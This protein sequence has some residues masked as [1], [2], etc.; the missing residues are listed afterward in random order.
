MNTGEALWLHVPTGEIVDVREHESTVRSSPQTF[1]LTPEKAQ[2]IRTREDLLK[3]VMK[4][5]WVRMRRH[6]EYIAFEHMYPNRV[7]LNLALMRLMKERRGIIHSNDTI[8]VSHVTQGVDFEGKASEFIDR[9]AASRGREPANIPQDRDDWGRETEITDILRKRLL[10]RAGVWESAR[11]GKRLEMVLEETQKIQNELS[12]ATERG[13][14]GT[15]SE[16]GLARLWAKTK[17]PFAMLTGFRHENPLPVNIQFN[18]DILQFL[19]ARRMGAYKTIGYWREAPEGMAYL[20]AEKAGL[21]KDISEDSFFVP[22]PATMPL[23]DFREIVIQILRKYRQDA[24]IYGDGEKIVLLFRDGTEQQIGTKPTFNKIAQ[25]YSRMRNKPEV[26]F[27]FEG[28][29]VPINVISRMAF[30]ARG[31]LYPIED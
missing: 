14:I 25:A 9:Y 8:W 6:R 21:L 24:A 29:A 11:W 13:G 2:Q 1:G 10:Q 22:K 26:P 27:V 31:L 12:E 4:N 7:D 19:N 5:G 16:A 23:E 17:E 28:I 15:L 20:D 30:H 18:R 3:T